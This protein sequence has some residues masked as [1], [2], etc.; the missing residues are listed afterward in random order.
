MTHR[1]LSVL[2]AALAAG[3][4]SAPD[5]PEGW[6]EAEPVDSFEQTECGGDP[7]EGDYEETVEVVA[8]TGSIEIGYAEAHFRCEQDVEAFYLLEGDTLSVLVQPID[9]D[10]RETAKCDCLYDI[11]LTVLELPAGALTVDVFRRW[12]NINDDNEPVW[13][14]SAEVEID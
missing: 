4:L 11:D 10:P 6:E 13:V 8:G 9:M 12:D 1:T 3:C 2:L 14:G 5:F 7:Y